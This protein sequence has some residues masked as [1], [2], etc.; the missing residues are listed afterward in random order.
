[1]L[2]ESL[3]QCLDARLCTEETSCEIVNQI[4]VL[5]AKRQE[6]AILEASFQ[7]ISNQHL[8]FD[9]KAVASPLLLQLKRCDLRVQKIVAKL[10]TIQA[11]KFPSLIIPVGL[12]SLFFKGESFT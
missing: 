4:L 12:L 7:S 6:P 5:I 11:I 10:L 8:R 3:T 2:L 1:M 9:L